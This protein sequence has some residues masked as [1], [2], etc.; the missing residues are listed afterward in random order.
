[1]IVHGE[2]FNETL[3]LSGVPNK[4]TIE[5]NSIF[6]LHGIVTS[7]TIKLSIVFTRAGALSVQP[8]T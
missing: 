3:L 4:V 5:I 6:T 2:I 1:M 7:H 8:N